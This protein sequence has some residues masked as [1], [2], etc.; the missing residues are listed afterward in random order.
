MPNTTKLGN[1]I[2][3]LKKELRLPPVKPSQTHRNRKYDTKLRRKERFS[4]E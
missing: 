4:E 2:K 3:Q 1:R